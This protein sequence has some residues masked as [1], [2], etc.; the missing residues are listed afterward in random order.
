[1]VNFFQY[2]SQAEIRTENR[3][4]LKPKS[5]KNGARIFSFRREIFSTP[6]PKQKSSQTTFFRTE[7]HRIFQTGKERQNLW[8][9]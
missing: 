4:N 2:T 8:E 9:K 5:P 6:E 3:P 1:T 7:I